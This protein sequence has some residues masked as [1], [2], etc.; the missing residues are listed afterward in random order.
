MSL[1]RQSTPNPSAMRLTSAREV[2]T[3]R[4]L[5]SW[6]TPPEVAGE[7]IVWSALV[8]GS[9]PVHEQTMAVHADHSRKF[10]GMRSHPFDGRF[11]VRAAFDTVSPDRKFNR[12]SVQ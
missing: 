5:F 2:N 8:I 6:A 12:F 11:A 7:S 4:Q 3:P 1:I 9:I 10:I